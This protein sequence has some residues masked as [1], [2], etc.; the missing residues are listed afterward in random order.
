MF[1][2]RFDFF[3]YLYW[4][5]LKDSQTS[6]SLHTKVCITFFKLTSGQTEP[7]FKTQV[8]SCS[9]E[10][11]VASETCAPAVPLRPSWLFFASLFC[12]LRARCTLESIY[13]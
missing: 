3:F 4:N 7:S 8:S 11:T 9:C 5:P 1:V 13:Y 12:L 10:V 2:S 6:C